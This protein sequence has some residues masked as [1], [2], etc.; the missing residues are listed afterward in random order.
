MSCQYHLFFSIIDVQVYKNFHVL[1]TENVYSAV[2]Y[3]LKRP[4]HATVF[5]VL[6]TVQYTALCLYC[7]LYSILHCV[8]IV[9]CTVYCTVSASRDITEGKS[10]GL[11]TRGLCGCWTHKKEAIIS[12]D[13]LFNVCTALLLSRKFL[14]DI[15]KKISF[16]SATMIYKYEVQ[17][18]LLVMIPIASTAAIIKFFNRIYKHFIN[19]SKKNNFI[20]LVMFLIVRAPVIIIFYSILCKCFRKAFI[21]L[22]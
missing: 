22:F 11:L 1:N 18:F 6:C 3:L 17:L 7:V 9:C 20:L 4:F 14:Q 19:A 10:L 2:V 13:C 16:D 5:P 8:C 12:W 21:C 15:P